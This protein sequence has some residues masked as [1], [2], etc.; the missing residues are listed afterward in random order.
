[1]KQNSLKFC[2][3]LNNSV[4][5]RCVMKW[6]Q[7]CRRRGSVTARLRCIHC[8]LFFFFWDMMQQ[9]AGSWKEEMTAALLCCTSS[10]R[11]TETRDTHSFHLTA[12]AT[13]TPK[14]FHLKKSSSNL[15]TVSKKHHSQR[16]QEWISSQRW[17]F[18]Y[19]TTMIRLWL[20][21]PAGHKPT[22]QLHRWRSPSALNSTS[23][24]LTLTWGTQA[25][26]QTVSGHNFS[27]F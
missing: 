9:N 25:V 14:H 6:R 20:D 17:L 4:C 5:Y 23:E 15:L 16:R 21:G 24:K 3:Q 13:Q 1:M 18:Y 10:L 8:F 19:F 11:P 27:V 12:A 22:Q 2:W 26:V 7:R